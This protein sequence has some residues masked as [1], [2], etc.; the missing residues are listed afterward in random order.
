KS[1]YIYANI[2][3]NIDDVEMGVHEH[4]TPPTYSWNGM[5]MQKGERKTFGEVVLEF[6]TEIVSRGFVK[7]MRWNKVMIIREEGRR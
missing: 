7:R 6:T 2:P 3:A 4:T 5:V 1:G